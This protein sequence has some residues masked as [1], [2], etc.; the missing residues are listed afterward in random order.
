MKIKNLLFC[1]ALS[2]GFNLQSGNLAILLAKTNPNIRALL[3]EK[4]T[5]TEQFNAMC[6][7]T[8][9][10]GTIKLKHRKANTLQII[11]ESNEEPDDAYDEKEE[12]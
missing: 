3:L 8:R 4:T 1:I 9:A 10:P 2:I 5:T 6:D 12:E 7:A 11:T